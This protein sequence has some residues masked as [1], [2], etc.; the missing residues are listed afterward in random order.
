MTQ[1]QDTESQKSSKVCL[2]VRICLCL[3]CVLFS[4]TIIELIVHVF[5][6][7]FTYHYLLYCTLYMTNTNTVLGI[8]CIWHCP[9]RCRSYWT[10]FSPDHYEVNVFDKLYIAMRVIFCMTNSLY[11]YRSYWRI[12]I[13][14]WKLL[15]MIISRPL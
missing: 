11:H 4:S 12:F 3:R 13:L 14:P 1:Y 15:Y 8:Y 9:Y 10:W 7:F 5:K 2:Y 6:S